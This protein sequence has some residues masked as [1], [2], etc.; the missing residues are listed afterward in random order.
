MLLGQQHQAAQKH[1]PILATH[2]ED[3]DARPVMNDRWYTQPVLTETQPPISPSVNRQHSYPGD[4]YAPGFQIGLPGSAVRNLPYSSR[5]LRTTKVQTGLTEEQIES[6]EDRSSSSDEENID[7]SPLD[8]VL[9]TPTVLEQRVRLEWQ[10]M[11]RSVLDGDVFTAEKAR[12]GIAEPE[13]ESIDPVEKFKAQFASDDSWLECRGKLRNRTLDEERKRIEHRRLRI[14]DTLHEDVLAFNFDENS[15]ESAA[16]QINHYLRRLDVVESFY[17]TL[18]AMY[19]DK[20]SLKDQRFT[21]RIDAMTSWVN[22]AGSI[23]QHRALLQ[24]WTGSSTLDV[25]APNTTSEVPIGSQRR[26]HNEYINEPADDSTFVQRVLKEHSIVQIFKKRALLDAVSIISRANDVYLTYSDEF[27]AM[28]LPSLKEELYE[29]MTFP[30]KLMKESLRVQLDYANRI[31]DMDILLIDQMLE[32]FKVSTGEACARKT[33]Y[34]S[35]MAASNI[36]EECIDDDYDMTVLEAV[37][38]FFG[39]LHRKLKSGAGSTASYFRETEFLDSQ[40][41]LLDRVALEITGGSVLVAEQ[42]WCVLLYPM[43]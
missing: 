7:T 38:T 15:G 3:E 27:E 11:L 19:A 31:R 20:P 18:K 39:L 37:T 5:Q 1:T 16:S 6:E 21:A 8:I 23:S 10:T 2:V 13:T 42:L 36:L 40:W 9:V 43:P 41:G 4:T 32:D 30:T 33:E 14:G 28:K 22:L 35:L 12:V 24:K 26:L 34:R 29:L 25:I 17:P